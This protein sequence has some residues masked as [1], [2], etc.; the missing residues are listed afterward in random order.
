M[1]HL[2]NMRREGGIPQ[3]LASLLR[4]YGVGE[5]GGL[6]GGWGT[7]GKQADKESGKEV[8]RAH[9]FGARNDACRVRCVVSFSGV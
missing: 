3:R 4:G 2:E 9:S 5:V 7:D 1:C 6:V 8:G